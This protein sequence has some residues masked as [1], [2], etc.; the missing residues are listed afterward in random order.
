M[1]S[2]PSLFACCMQGVI[3]FPC[4]ILPGTEAGVGSKLR[5]GAG[6]GLDIIMVS[7]L[8]AVQLEATFVL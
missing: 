4:G 3:S 1:A 7:N 6:T 2:L 8:G 5:R